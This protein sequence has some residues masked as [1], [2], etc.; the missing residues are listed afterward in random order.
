V[1]LARLVS[2][3]FFVQVWSFLVCALIALDTDRMSTCVTM[4]ECARRGSHTIF[5]PVA[6]VAPSQGGVLLFHCPR[7]H[8]PLHDCS[9]I[10]L[11]LVCMPVLPAP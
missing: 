8:H 4:A 9:I 11:G 10:S 6:S 3:E 5:T 2:Q 7:D 1:P